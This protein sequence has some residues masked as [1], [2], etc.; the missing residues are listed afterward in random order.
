[1]I[2]GRWV[3]EQCAQ[4]ISSPEKMNE[5]T[6]PLIT[7]IV[8]NEQEYCVFNHLGKGDMITHSKC[9]YNSFLVA[10]LQYVSYTVITLSYLDQTVRSLRYY[11]KDLT[12]PSKTVVFLA[13][14]INLT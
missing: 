7:Q 13:N 4:R 2:D 9:N 12:I 6:T 11:I 5:K 8:K 14:L 10:K 1:M 3:A